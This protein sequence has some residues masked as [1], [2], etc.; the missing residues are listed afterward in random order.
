VR[1]LLAADDIGA[2]WAAMAPL[3]RREVAR[4]VFPRGITVHPDLE[5]PRVRG[6]FVFNSKRLVPVES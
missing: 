3:D 6:A 4:A 1:V 5:R 2:A